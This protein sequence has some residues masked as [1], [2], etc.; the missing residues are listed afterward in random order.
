MTGYIKDVL[1]AC[2]KLNIAVR[3]MFGEN[4][5]ASG[6]MFQISNQVTLGQTE[7]DIIAGVKNAADQITEQE[8]ILRS[9]AIQTEF[10]QV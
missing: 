10:I 5:E 7:E 4:S 9:E 1:E 2:G 6:G 3:G 8:K